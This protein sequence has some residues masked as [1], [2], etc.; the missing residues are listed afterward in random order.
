MSPFVYQSTMLPMVPRQLQASCPNPHISF[1]IYRLASV[2]GALQL[3]PETSAT[4]ASCKGLT[5]AAPSVSLLP[6]GL[7]LAVPV[8]SSV[9][10][11]EPRDFSPY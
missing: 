10:G 1:E 5:A 9:G 6:L 7:F 4:P 8:G 2:T 11:A 3:S